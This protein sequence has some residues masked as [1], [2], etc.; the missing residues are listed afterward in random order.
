[1]NDESAVRFHDGV[2]YPNLA[3]LEMTA[4]FFAGNFVYH[5]NIFRRNSCRASFFGFLFINGFTS[6]CITEATNPNV[7]RYYAAA[8]NNTLE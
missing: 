5:K 6:Y 3:Y 2:V 7:A 4:M 8:Y 1:M